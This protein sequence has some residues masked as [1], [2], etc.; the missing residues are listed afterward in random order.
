MGEYSVNRT[1]GR[2]HC[3]VIREVRVWESTLSIER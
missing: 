3:G 1:I 2:V